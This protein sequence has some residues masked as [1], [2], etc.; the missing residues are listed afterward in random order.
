MKLNAKQVDQAKFIRPISPLVVFRSQENPPVAKNYR[1]EVL[2]E[3]Y[4]GF[5]IERD[6]GL[7]IFG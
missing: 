6:D 7:G 2:G 1:E 5:R 4:L 3:R